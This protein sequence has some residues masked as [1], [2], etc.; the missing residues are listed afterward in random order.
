MH[1]NAAWADHLKDGGDR[2]T[3]LQNNDGGWDWP[4][5]NGNP[6]SGSAANT[7]GPIGMGLAETY[8]FTNDSAHLAALSQVGAFLITKTN[9]FSP[10]DGYLAAKL[11]QVFGGSTYT[12]HVLNNFYRPLQQGIYDKDG[13]GT[14]YSTD[15]YIQRI[16]D[17]RSGTQ[18]NLAA[19]DIGMG[20]VG[21]ASAG[22]SSSEINKWV[23]GVEAEIN[24]LE[25]DGSQYYDVIGLAGAIYGLSF[26]GEDFDPT[27]GEHQAAS[28]IIDLANILVSYQLP[29][30]GFTWTATATGVGDETVQE[31]SYAILA[32]NQID[33][34]TFNN[35]IN[36]AALYLR[37]IQLGTGGWEN[38]QGYG[39]N[40]EITAEALWALTKENVNIPEI[41]FGAKTT[42]SNSS[43]VK[44]GLSQ[45]KVEFD[46][47]VLHDGSNKS[48][49]NVNNY[50]LIEAG[51]NGTFDTA[52]CAVPGGPSAA[53]DDIQIAI[54]TVVYD[55]S[56][57]FISTLTVNGGNDLPEGKYR[58]FVCGTT[59]IENLYGIELNDGVSDSTIEFTV[60]LSTSSSTTTATSSKFELP[61]TGF[62][63]NQFTNLPT[64]LIEK[65]YSSSGLVLQ[66]PDLNLSLDIVGVPQVDNSWDTSWLG[67]NVGWLN[68][69]AFPTWA[70]NTVLTG[71][72]WNNTNTPGVFA[73]IK[74]LGYGQIIQ[75]INNGEVYT[76]QVVSNQLINNNQIK[77]A[78][79]HEKFDTI[80]LLTCENYSEMTQT[81]QNRR[82]I[83]A[84]LVSVE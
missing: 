83:K 13:A 25:G 82:M 5:D 54:D 60:S 51:V 74:E 67:Q 57:P 22:V 40:N 84:V 47:D 20:L 42:P 52:S 45:I 81:Y 43:I 59:S 72:V 29:S 53:Q 8:M 2:L 33:P 44:S 9:N 77:L 79:S 68:G 56:G 12:N 78:F 46:Q 3:A 15:S 66:I 41:V 31:T 35:Q 11:D 49:N 28:N 34:T 38:Y 6:N 23:I 24:E 69:S 64:Q 7:I 1:T 30:G 21:A 62:A 10:S 16:R 36:N 73:N 75:I 61:S 48:A 19:W 76:Y 55:A 37:S 39:E 26:V 4:L 58:L 63:M 14:L 17:V 27:S 70:G 32:L 80:T 50:L 71:H 18:A 65:A